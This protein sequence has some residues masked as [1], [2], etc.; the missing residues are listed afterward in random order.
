MRRILNIAQIS[1]KAEN[2]KGGI[3]GFFC[4]HQYAH[5]TKSGRLPIHRGLKGIDYAIYSVFP[6]LNL[7]IGI[8]PIVQND[9]GNL[10]SMYVDQL[11]SLGDWGHGVE[12]VEDFVDKLNATAADHA[13]DL[14][15]DPALDY[16]VDEIH[17]KNLEGFGAFS[18]QYRAQRWQE[19]RTTVGTKLHGPTFDKS[20]AGDAELV[21]RL[22]VSFCFLFCSRVYRTL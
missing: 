22:A 4:Y 15:Y 20:C 13:S 8:H 12:P 16:E 1:K 2:V 5:S 10:G 14:G 3:L 18:S 21:S 7:G 17:Y 9:P 11:M 19:R 6:A